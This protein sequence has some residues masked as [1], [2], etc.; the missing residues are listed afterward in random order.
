MLP[1]RSRS[2][3]QR[4]WGFLAGDRSDLPFQPFEIELAALHAGILQV[5]LENAGLIAHLAETS[6]ALGSSYEGMEEAYEAL[7]EAQ[8]A[9]GAQ[10]QKTALGGLFLN[11]A[12]RLQIPV[13]VLKEESA[14]L[15]TIVDRTGQPPPR[16]LGESQRAMAQIRSA[17]TQVDGLVRSLLRRA[18][19]GEAKSP[20][21][22]HLH[23]LLREEV[24]LLRAEGLLPESLP[25]D[26]N[27]QAPR[28]LLYGVYSDFT[29][30]F[31]HLIGHALEGG[32]KRISVRTWGGHSH[33]RIELEDDGTPI[34]PGLLAGAFE[35]FPDLRPVMT[36]PGRRPGQGLPACAQLMNTYNGNV[37]IEPVERGSLVRISFPME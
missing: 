16:D 30:V 24:D 37:Q 35:P 20:E 34:D 13:A 3:D 14:A 10:N 21:W 22:I 15:S 1:L 33:F 17:I 25:V 29:E 11:M 12:Q 28:D 27:L 23:D 2:E 6:Q 31:G 9:L 7:K 18:G 36:G 5:S 32:P 4:L 26:F 19:Q 8:R